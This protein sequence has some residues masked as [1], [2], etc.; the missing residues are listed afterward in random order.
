MD[1]ENPNYK[2]MAGEYIYEHVEKVAGK[3]KAPRV[4][5]LL[6]DLPIEEIKAYLYDYN[7]LL[8]KIGEALNLID[9]LSLAYPDVNVHK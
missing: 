1:L 2:N 5:G 4:T 6:I 9:N 8:I 7:R 3:E